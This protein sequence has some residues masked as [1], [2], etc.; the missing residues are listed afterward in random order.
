MAREANW[1]RELCREHAGGKVLKHGAI[2]VAERGAADGRCEAMTRPADA[3]KFS[4]RCD[5]RRFE[6]FLY[7]HQKG[8]CMFATLQLGRSAAVEWL[9]ER[10]DDSEE[11][12]PT[13][14]W[15]MPWD[16]SAG[17]RTNANVKLRS[18]RRLSNSPSRVRFKFPGLV[19]RPYRS[20]AFG[21]FCRQNGDAQR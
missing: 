21:A 18:L 17:R 2:D 11:S 9:L 8:A 7:F 15:Q 16:P 1:P 10:I 5:E 13:I 6:R 4:L 20:R 12:S 14:A 19:R 3:K